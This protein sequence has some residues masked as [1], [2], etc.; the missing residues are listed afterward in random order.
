MPHVVLIARTADEDS[1]WGTLILADQ[2]SN[3]NNQVAV[4]FTAEAL[5]ALHEGTLRWSP[6]LSA[7]DT[8][9]AITRRAVELGY[10]FND[11]SRDPRWTD[12]RSWLDTYAVEERIRLF[13]CPIW[14]ALLGLDA[15]A[16]PA[17][18]RI[19]N[20]AY[21][22]LLAAADTVIGGL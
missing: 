13:A 1:L 15:S 22:D 9:A 14:S 16:V 8:R 21:A 20:D 10:E 18:E 11:K 19:D 3:R 17:L 6:N 2:L 7:R 5:D 12:F 4:V